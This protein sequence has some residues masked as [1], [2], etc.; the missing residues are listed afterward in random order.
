MN[1]F[2]ATKNNI[3]KSERGN[4]CCQLFVTGKGNACVVPII[5]ELEALLG[6]KLFAK[7]LGVTGAIITD[8]AVTEAS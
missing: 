6:M 7:D 2:H 8:T 4:T 3:L 5:K 1:T